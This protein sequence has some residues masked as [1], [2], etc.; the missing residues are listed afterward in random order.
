MKKK[1]REYSINIVIILT[2]IVSTILN[3][4][5]FIPDERLPAYL[6]LADVGLAICVFYTALKYEDTVKELGDRLTHGTSR[7]VTRKEHYK[8][9]KE[10][11]NNARSHIMIMTIDPALSRGMINSIQER[12]EYYRRIE[13]IAKE[14]HRIIIRRIHGLPDD[15]SARKDKIEWINAELEKIHDCPNY[16][17]RIFDWRKF[18]KIPTPLSLQIVD[19]TFVGLVNMQHPSEGIVGSGED[20]CIIDSNVVQHLSLYYNDIWEKCE[21]LKEGDSIDRR[22]IDS[23]FSQ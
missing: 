6:L 23:N 7:K 15:E 2:I 22:L 3:F 12:E 20:I 4:I 5:G 13:Q 18:G 16:H 8:L 14:N 19:D 9:L 11:V 1:L 10:A 17:I 21:R